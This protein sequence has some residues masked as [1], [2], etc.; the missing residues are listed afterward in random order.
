MAEEFGPDAEVL[1]R[2][3]LHEAAMR[4][5][6]EADEAAQRFRPPYLDAGRTGPL[7]DRVEAEHAAAYEAA[8]RSARYYNDGVEEHPENQYLKILADSQSVKAPELSD[9]QWFSKNPGFLTA[10]PRTDDERTANARLEFILR[11]VHE[12]QRDENPHDPMSWASY[13]GPLAGPMTEHSV[14]ALRAAQDAAFLENLQ[15]PYTHRKLFRT[16]EGE[17]L[18][19]YDKESGHYPA[20]AEAAQLAATVYGYG[21]WFKPIMAFNAMATA[22]NTAIP[23]TQELFGGRPG[24][25]LDVL[26]RYPLGVLNPEYS[27]GRK[28][29]PYDWRGG[30]VP[31][32][33][34]VAA[35]TLAETVPWF[36][37]PRLRGRQRI[38][39]LAKE[40]KSWRDLS[41]ADAAEA[42]RIRRSFLMR[43]HPDHARSNPGVADDSVMRRLNELVDTGDLAGLRAFARQL[44]MA[45]GPAR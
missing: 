17:P 9:W 12:A 5:L 32:E 37:A 16:E 4:R 45:A 33:F 38:P 26:A 44:E 34:A 11:R 21:K 25:A 18:P 35:D 20:M 22:H 40:V 14:L 7:R 39:A 30:G 15:S 28:G 3:Q 2:R 13:R 10:S 41:A 36:W 8:Q 24:A 19:W 43:Y 27:A 6:K 29:G 23:A 31:A 1:R 42:N